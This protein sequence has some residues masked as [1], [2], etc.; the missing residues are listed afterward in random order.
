MCRPSVSGSYE[1]LSD[2]KD[3]LELSSQKPAEPVNETQGEVMPLA[4][5]SARRMSNRIPR[6]V[7]QS[8]TMETPVDTSGAMKMTYWF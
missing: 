7:R 8:S 5:D 4:K 6:L 1:D 3:S 2:D